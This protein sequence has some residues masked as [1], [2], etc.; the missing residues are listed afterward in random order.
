MLPIYVMY[1]SGLDELE[2][3]AISDAIQK[4]KVMVT[5]LE[6]RNYGSA[7]WS[8][9]AYSSADWY[10]QHAE[11]VHGNYGGMQLNADSL[12]D[13]VAGE[14]WRVNDPHI[15]IIV[16]SYDITA[17]DDGKQLNFV[18]GLADFGKGVSI[19]SV[20]RFRGCSDLERFLAIETLIWHELGHIL[21][22]A[23]DPRRPHTEEKLGRH[24][25]NYGCV[26]RQGMSV[27]EWIEHARD[28]WQAGQIYC[29]ECISDAFVPAH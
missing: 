27:P 15:D 13:L 11:I 9:G 20:F 8:T 21:G 28:A 2:R 3:D 4:I 22:M 26:M 14:P 1:D 12:I 10:I 5:G 24:C 7:A 18:L 16:T 25:T 23:A 29:P 6:I 17:L 19:Q